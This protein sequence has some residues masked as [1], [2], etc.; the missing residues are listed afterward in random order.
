MHLSS[1]VPPLPSPLLP[2][3]DLHFWDAPDDILGAD[4]DLLFE[5]DRVYLHNATGHFGALPLSVSGQG[6]R[7]GGANGRR[8]RPFK[9]A[10]EAEGATD[11]GFICLEL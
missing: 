9:G 6:G 2:G 4:M 11:C 1:A 3:V 10:A 5:K 8:G 7:R